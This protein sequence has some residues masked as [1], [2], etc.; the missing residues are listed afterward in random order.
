MSAIVDLTQIAEHLL[1]LVVK[2]YA[3]KN[4]LNEVQAKPAYENDAKL[5]ELH[6]D[7]RDLKLTMVELQLSKNASS[8]MH[9]AQEQF[10]TAINFQQIC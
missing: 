1:D 9:I 6:K 7:L 5:R 3:L 10:P 2:V 4:E 8:Q